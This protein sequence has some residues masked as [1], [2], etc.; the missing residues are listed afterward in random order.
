MRRLRIR[1]TYL[2]LGTK[3]GKFPKPVS[4]EKTRRRN[5]V[6]QH[7][8]D[9]FYCKNDYTI[10]SLRRSA[11]SRT[12]YLKILAIFTKFCQR[13]QWLRNGGGEYRVHYNSPKYLVGGV[14]SIICTTPANK[15]KT[16]QQVYENARALRDFRGDI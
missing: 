5:E 13:F 4:W 3:V 1:F 10:E 6:T 12:L 14:Q 8:W 11:I 9:K 15:L 7:Q 16:I 2:A